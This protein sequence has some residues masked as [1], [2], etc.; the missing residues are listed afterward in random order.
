MNSVR[1]EGSAPAESLLWH[2]QGRVTGAMGVPVLEQRPGDCYIWGSCEASPGNA[3]S[4]GPS[5][6]G[7]PLGACAW[8]H[9]EVP[10]LVSDAHHLDVAEVGAKGATTLKSPTKKPYKLIAGGLYTA[11]DSDP[12]MQPA[13]IPSCL[14]GCVTCCFA[15]VE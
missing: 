6:G 11:L 1:A 8:Q 7:A 12:G 9:S 10:I 15:Y 5:P 4:R 2:V 3:G 14:S 13:H